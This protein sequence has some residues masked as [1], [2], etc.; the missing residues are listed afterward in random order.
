[1]PEI[2]KS[3]AASNEF[4]QELLSRDETAAG[5]MARRWLRVED[6][7]R[8]R[9]ERLTAQIQ[10]AQAN[11]QE[12]SRVWLLQQDRYINLLGQLTGEIDKFNRYSGG[13]IDAL[14]ADAVGFARVTAA[15]LILATASD[16][17]AVGLTFDR[18]SI[19][20]AENIA[21]LARA[22]QPLD[23]LLQLNY[24]TAVQG[25]TDRLITGVAVGVNP[26]EVARDIINNGLSQAYSHTILVARDQ[27]LRAYR[28]ATA[29]AY[30]NSGIVTRYKRLAAKNDRTCLACLALDGEL[31][32]VQ[33]LMP[34]H[35][36][37]RCT[38]LP[39]LAQFAPVNFQTGEAW[40]RK[41][42]QS[43]QRKALGPGRFDLWQ[44]GGF[45]FKQLATVRPNDTWGPNA[46]ETPLKDLR[47]GRGGLPSRP[48]QTPLPIG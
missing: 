19:E 4:R 22:G 17:G 38:M 43:Y 44:R 36:Q 40:F 46:V 29:Q 27:H 11:G 2:P 20:A 24:P 1:M 16:V 45:S 21:A 5:Q 15:D 47:A 26:R 37:D 35:P 9:L 34:L 7:V 33:E 12:I 32:D 42:P 14:Q 8:D 6:S 25:I 10:E 23:N 30:Q 28:T 13:I 41:Q 31:F 39:V 3:V 48:I 18:L